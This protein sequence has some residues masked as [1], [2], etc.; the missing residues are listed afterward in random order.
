MKHVFQDDRML[1]KYHG[2]HSSYHNLWRKPLLYISTLRMNLHISL[3]QIYAFTK[4]VVETLLKVK[5]S[6]RNTWQ[7]HSHKIV[8]AITNEQLHNI[9]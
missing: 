7:T 3:V 5:T 6:L 8:S 2:I 4:P 9:P 1:S